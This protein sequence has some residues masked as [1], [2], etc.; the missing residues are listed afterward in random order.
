[1]QSLRHRPVIHK[2]H[3]EGLSP[4]VTYN[5]RNIKNTLHSRDTIV[6]TSFFTK[7]KAI[8]KQRHD[9]N[10]KRCPRGSCDTL[11]NTCHVVAP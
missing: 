9:E 5:Y 1:M 7:F 6:H 4:T 2:S 11:R 8:V 10:C 3:Q